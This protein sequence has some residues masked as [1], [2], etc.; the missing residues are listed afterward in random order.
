MFLDSYVLLGAC[1]TITDVAVYG[2]SVSVVCL[3]ILVEQ[4]VG[5]L[6]KA[7]TYAM[8]TSRHATGLL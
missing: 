8:S 5:F 4:N 1:V 3:F 2:F 6:L 7:C